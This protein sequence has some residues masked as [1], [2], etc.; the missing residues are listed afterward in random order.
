[1]GL[2]DK[3]KNVGIDY[4]SMQLGRSIHTFIPVIEH[5]DD[6]VANTWNLWEWFVEYQVHKKNLDIPQF[7]Q[8]LK[9]FG[10][11]P[12]A[13]TYQYI[14][15]DQASR[16]FQDKLQLEIKNLLRPHLSVAFLPQSYSM[17]PGPLIS[18]VFPKV[19]SPLG[20]GED[21]DAQISTI[22]S[23]YDFKHATDEEL[24]FT[25]LVV[26]ESF[27][28]ILKETNDLERKL[29]VPIRLTAWEI[30][31]LYPVFLLSRHME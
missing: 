19:K 17:E 9:T 23:N 18:G 5:D 1:M 28:S 30:L 13:P 27:V 10:R 16:N 29:R 21:L 3:Y 4:V 26:S 15:T 11:T 25:A 8:I 24:F 20:Y 6:L 31:P 2:F 7:V 22:L 14:G 12:Q